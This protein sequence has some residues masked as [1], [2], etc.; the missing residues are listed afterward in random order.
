MRKNDKYGKK[1]HMLIPA[2]AHTYSRMDEVFPGNAPRVKER[3]KGV[4]T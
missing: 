3:S 1:A 4:Y 2:S